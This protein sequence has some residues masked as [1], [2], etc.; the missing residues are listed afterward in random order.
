[1]CIYSFLENV[2]ILAVLGL[3]C[4][5]WAISGR[6]DR[7]L[8]FLVEPAS[9]CSGFSCCRARALELLGFSGICGAQA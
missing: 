2:F 4:C 1:M 9:H 7:E 5:A 8:L 3:R 6:G